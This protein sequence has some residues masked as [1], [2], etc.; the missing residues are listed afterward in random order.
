MHSFLKTSSLV[1]VIT[2]SSCLPKP[3]TSQV[4]G[5]YREELKVP[6]YQLKEKA[7]VAA[8]ALEQAGWLSGDIPNPFSSPKRL[9]DEFVC[10]A[11]HESSFIPETYNTAKTPEGG[12]KNHV[13]LWQIQ[14]PTH[15]NRSVQVND[16]VY[17]CP[18]KS[19]KDLQNPCI[20]AQC[21][22]FVYM[23]R[24]SWKL[25]IDNIFAA[26]EGRCEESV[27]GQNPPSI[28]C[29]AEARKICEPTPKC[30]V[31]ANF[32][33]HVVPGEKSE[34]RDRIFRIGIQ[35]GGNCLDAKKIVLKKM[36]D[37]RR[38]VR[39]EYLAN[40]KEALRK[41]L[42][43]VN[44]ENYLTMKDGV[45]SLRNEYAKEWSL[46][47]S[48][49]R[50]ITY[51]SSPWGAVQTQPSLIRKEGE[52][53]F[54]ASA[55]QLDI[56]SARPSDFLQVVVIDSKGHEFHSAQFEFQVPIGFRASEQE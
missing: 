36:N 47:T 28:D 26:W 8:C 41:K 40:K 7:S 33:E 23:E 22:L 10:V 46:F 5:D 45:Q 25:S 13:G 27:G 34:T 6:A 30:V 50:P 21:A 24:A 39:L 51:S 9:R 11:Y 16:K 53:T 1:I 48:L 18:A 42:K 35:L 19:L 44:R 3:N 43:V 2:V 38:A 49:Y 37:R 56:L 17:S 31:K 14:Y 20:N 29:S 55:Q 32:G 4:A 12:L 15:L 54:Y 52:T